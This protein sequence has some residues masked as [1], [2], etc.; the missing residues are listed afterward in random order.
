MLSLLHLELAKCEEM[1]VMYSIACLYG[2]E[3]PYTHR[4]GMK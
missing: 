3:D 4:Q 2:E 1:Q